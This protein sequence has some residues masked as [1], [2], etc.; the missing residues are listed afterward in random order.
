MHPNP[1]FRQTGTERNITFARSQGFGML[2]VSTPE[3]PLISHIPF[4]LNEAGTEATFHLVR[5]NPICRLVGEGVP[6][7]LAVI[8]PNGYISPD[9]YEMDDQVPTW[10]YVA[11]HLIGRMEQLSADSLHPMLDE[12]S[13]W[14]EATLDPKPRWRTEKM[15]KD[16]MARMM[17]HILPFR[18]VVN[19]IDSTWKLSQN[20]PEAAR[21][22]AARALSAHDRDLAEMMSDPP[23]D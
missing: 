18:L 17:R 9:W 16:A 15:P 3:A 20:K 5:S 7:R 21:L 2:A 6:A 13:E 8:G 19:E 10:N 22:A 4:L 12:L 11:V 23:D 14:F 1:A